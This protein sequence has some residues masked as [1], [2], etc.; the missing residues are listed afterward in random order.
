MDAA[1]GGLA[2]GGTR[3]G[4][5][6]AASWASRSEKSLILSQTLPVRR[7]REG[8]RNGGGADGKVR[9]GNEVVAAKTGVVDDSCIE[10]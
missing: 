5:R 9:Q 6:S 4:A 7:V 3:I 8:D 10:D 1:E 2:S